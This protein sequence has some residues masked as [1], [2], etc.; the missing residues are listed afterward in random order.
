MTMHRGSQGTLLCF[1]YISLLCFSFLP[2]IACA[3]Q[4]T[5]SVPIPFTNGSNDG[6][7]L[8]IVLNITL[9]PPS[10]ASDIASNS[11][12]ETGIMLNHDSITSTR[13]LLNGTIS[14]S[15]SSAWTV[16]SLDVIVNRT[17]TG[18]ATNVT[19]QGGFE[20]GA[21]S[22]PSGG[23]AL[24][25]LRLRVLVDHSLLEV[26]A[27]DGRGRIASR[28]YPLSSD[29]WTASLFATLQS[30]ASVTVEAAVYAMDSCW[31]ASV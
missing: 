26:F 11:T 17:L 13:V 30:S 22:L 18:G 31:V 28:I 24:D 27:N 15:N 7:Q 19:F 23:L 8:D 16:N 5:S 6:R 4:T 20:G 14:Q 21:V 29:N 2:D 3:L 10:A 12:F 25:D 9:Q 1:C